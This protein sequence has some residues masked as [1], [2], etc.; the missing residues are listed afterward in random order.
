MVLICVALVAT[1]DD[2]LMCLFSLYISSLMECYL[3]FYPFKKKLVSVLTMS[4]E[5][6][7]CVVNTIPLSDT[8]FINIPLNPYLIFSLIFLTMSFEG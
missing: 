4:F 7:S 3:H 8:C 1:Y 5:S 2:Y 6:S